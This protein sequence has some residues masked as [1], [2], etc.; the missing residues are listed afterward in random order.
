MFPIIFF[1]YAG[2]FG[3]DSGWWMVDPLMAGGRWYDR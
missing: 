2:H 1:F 3:C